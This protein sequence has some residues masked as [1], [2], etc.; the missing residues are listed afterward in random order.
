MEIFSSSGS[1][2]GKVAVSN[3]QSKI[4][5]TELGREEVLLEVASTYS[6]LYLLSSA[7]DQCGAPPPKFSR[8][9][10]QKFI[11]L[12]FCEL[13][14]WLLLVSLELPHG[15]VF[16]W[17]TAWGLCLADA[18]GMTGTFSPC[19][20]IS[21]RLDRGSLRSLGFPSVRGHSYKVSWVLGSRT[22]TI[23]LTWH[24]IRQNKLQDQPTVDM[25]QNIVAIF[26]VH[27]IN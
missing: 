17:W 7:A 8:L 18:A 6:L 10:L 24:F 22:C 26:S 19:S 11:A 16:N 3:I 5:K 15:T 21:K 4:D 27:P 12:W 20:L 1:L 14:G 2:L 9:K 25:Q 13:D 23:S